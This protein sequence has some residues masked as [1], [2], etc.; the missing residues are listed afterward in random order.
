MTPRWVYVEAKSEVER[1]FRGY[2]SGAFSG[3]NFMIALSGYTAAFDRSA[4]HDDDAL[5]GTVVAGFVSSI[6]QWAIWEEEWNS[7][8]DRFGVPYFHRKELKGGRGA[9]SAEEWR[10]DQHVEDFIDSLIVP[11]NKWTI[12]SVGSYMQ[13]SMYESA[14]RLYALDGTFNPYAECGRNCAIKTKDFLSGEL[15]SALPISFAFEKG[16]P[17]KGMLQDLMERCE[18]P[19]PIFRRPR[20]SKD[21]PELDRIDPPMIQLQAADLLAWEIR[22][23]K[24][25]HRDG[26][27][28]RRAL[29]R[30]SSTGRCIW[31]ELDISTLARL[32]RSAGIP[33]RT[34]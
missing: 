17:G 28:M 6:E 32:I 26:K 25:D 13:A 8:L 2:W 21:N 3:S 27:G 9:F 19:S 14:N 15:K 4:D 20:P 1:F 23:W 30:L 16:D 12:A 34:K 31:K 22:R 33:E 24:I 5:G 10:D 29:G 18:L 7:V 11:I